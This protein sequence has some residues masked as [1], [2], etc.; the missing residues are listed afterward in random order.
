[1]MIASSVI[2]AS[3]SI[4]VTAHAYTFRAFL[5]GLWRPQTRKQNPKG[6]M[7]RRTLSGCVTPAP[8]KNGAPISRQRAMTDAKRMRCNRGTSLSAVTQMSSKSSMRLRVVNLH[9]GN[10]F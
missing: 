9:K 6:D 5:R 3:Y 1:V 10:D 7:P 2:V 4:P 8:V